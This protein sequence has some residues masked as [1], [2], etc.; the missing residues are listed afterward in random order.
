MRVVRRGGGHPDG[1]RRP[2]AARCSSRPRAVQEHR[3][4]VRAAVQATTTL[5]RVPTATG[6]QPG[7][8]TRPGAVCWSRTRPGS[9]TCAERAAA[10]LDGVTVPAPSTD[11]QLA[12]GGARPATFTGPPVARS[13]ALVAEPGRPGRRRRGA[14]AGLHRLQGGLRAAAGPARRRAGSRWS[15][16]TCPASTARPGPTTAAD[17]APDLLAPDLVLVAGALR[18]ERP[19]APVHLLG[20]SFGGLV[21]RAAVLAAPAAF[22]SL[23]L[24]DSG[25]A[26]IEGGR[27]ALVDAME[28][29]LAAGGVTA[30][31][32]ATMALAP[33]RPGL[34]RAARGARRVPAG[35]VHDDARRPTSRASAGPSG[36]NPTARPN[37]PRSGCGCWSPAAWVTTPGRSQCSRTWPPGSARCSRWSPNAR[38][39]P[40][41]EN[42]A[43]LLDVLVPFWSVAG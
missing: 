7:W 8:S 18:S 5:P 27:R 32:E 17:Y 43:G 19:D 10:L 22:D 14:G 33:A 20:H 29:V 1:R 40:A 26:G 11:R 15:R 4:H 23:V 13:P 28:P 25:P 30:V 38:H 3:R 12:T 34:R 37:S 21:A 42:P 35:A 39:S 41:V 16:S 9:P 24:L 2:R 31:Y 36:P 6:D